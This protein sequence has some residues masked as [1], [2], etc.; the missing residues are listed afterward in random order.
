MGTS[1]GDLHRLLLPVQPAPRVQASANHR[2]NGKVA[3]LATAS[4]ASVEGLASTGT[5]AY[6]LI[7]V[8][9]RTCPGDVNRSP[10]LSLDCAV[11]RATEF[12]WFSLP[13]WGRWWPSLES[14]SLLRQDGR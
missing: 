3:A 13:R 12:T 11:P 8:E 4:A 6:I 7:A 14:L 2:F 9:A 5:Q 10:C 1:D